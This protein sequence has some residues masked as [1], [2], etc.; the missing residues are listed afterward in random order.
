MIART[1]TLASFIS[2]CLLTA[3]TWCLLWPQPKDEA[4][5]E[6]TPKSAST[7][8]DAA[9]IAA[10]LKEIDT[11]DSNQA[12]LDTAERLADLPLEAFPA[13]FDSVELFK[14]RALT[15]AA[16][17]LLIRWAS[18]D[19]AAAAQWSWMQLRGEGLWPYA[20][21]EIA[22]SWAWHDPAGL[23]DWTL[24]KMKAHKPGHRTMSLEETL[25]TESPV[26]DASHIQRVAQAL[27]KE[28]PRL[29]YTVLL[30]RGHSSSHDNLS[31]GLE[32]VEAIRDALLAFD[33]IDVSD[34][35]P[36]NLAYQLL[37]RWQ[38]IDLEDFVRSPHANLFEVKEGSW[39]VHQVITADD[40]K[41]L[42][43]AERASGAMAKIESYQGSSARQS[44]AS[45]IASSW[46]KI[47]PA[48]CWTWI[49]SLPEEFVAPAAAGYA[50]IDGAF[51][52][53][54]TL[55]RIE[56]LPATARSRAFV[57]AFNTWSRRNPGDPQDFDNW[58]PKRQQAWQ[59]LAAL[60]QLQSR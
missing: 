41:E 56:Q 5:P 48:A 52:L 54:Q 25:R 55:D 27:M 12:R 59:D 16:K 44:G 31:Q 58:S 42:P 20:F 38:E 43:S 10:L 4:P 35:D 47:D 32:T 17:V 53:E 29:A 19:G 14:D 22:A 50:S 45:V 39:S 11:A 15:N 18:I 60:K 2:A 33:K 3:G 49:G 26:L 36:D 40:W 7:A 1:A 8:P 13:A 57:A 24:E 51:H 9:R 23:T 28:K 34:M 21:K 46:A 30:S 6:T 37:Q